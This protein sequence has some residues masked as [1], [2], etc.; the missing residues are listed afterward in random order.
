MRSKFGG[1]GEK[2]NFIVKENAQAAARAEFTTVVQFISFSLSLFSLSL[3]ASKERAE[4]MFS[5]KSP[6]RPHM[7]LF[8]CMENL[9]LLGKKVVLFY[10]DLHNLVPMH[11]RSVWSPLVCKKKDKRMESLLQAHTFR[12]YVFHPFSTCIM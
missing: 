3:D 7:P 11:F 6:T 10:A 2:A 4:N 9:L 1:A 12:G 5:E 8:S